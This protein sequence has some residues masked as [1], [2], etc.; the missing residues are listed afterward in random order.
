MTSPLWNNR[1]QRA[2]MMKPA[3]GLVWNGGAL[4][5]L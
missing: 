2:V 4:T 3:M 1:L 5:A